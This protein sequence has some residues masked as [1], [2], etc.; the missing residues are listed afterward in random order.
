MT[1]EQIQKYKD[2]GW[3]FKKDKW[4]N[5][6]NGNPEVD[7]IVTSPRLKFEKITL[8]INKWED[9]S[10]EYLNEREINT[11][12]YMLREKYKYKINDEIYK[13]FEKV[14]KGEHTGKE[15]PISFTIKL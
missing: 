1:K 12:T 14:A 5:Y 9:L 4:T 3:T 2:K 7:F 15:L 8:H 6:H 13:F 10:E 11:Y